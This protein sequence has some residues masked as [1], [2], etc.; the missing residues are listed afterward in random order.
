MN[1]R[2]Y[3]NLLISTLSF[4]KYSWPLMLIVPGFLITWSCFSGNKAIRKSHPKPQEIPAC[5]IMEADADFCYTQADY[6]CALVLYNKLI[7]MYPDSARYYYKRG[8]VYQK[9]KDS[10][11]CIDD[12]FQAIV[13]SDSLEYEYFYYRG[14]EYFKNNNLNLAKKD[15]TQSITLNDNCGNCYNYLGL[16]QGQ[17]YEGEQAVHS[18][19]K[20]IV[21]N[22][23]KLEYRLNLT[24]EFIRQN[25]YDSSLAVLNKTIEMDS[26]QYL[27]YFYRAIVNYEKENEYSGDNDLLH[28]LKLHEKTIDL[29]L[30]QVKQYT[31][32][33]GLVIADRMLRMISEVYPERTDI[34]AERAQVNLYQKN[35]DISL[36]L[37]SR[38]LELNP[39]NQEW[40]LQ[41]AKLSLQQQHFSE[42][43]SDY[44]KLIQNHPD[45]AKFYI[46]R[47]YANY[48]TG[49]LS[50]AR[51]DWDRAL[52]LGDP[53]AQEYI[54]T[55][56]PK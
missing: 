4:M 34:Y 8:N 22:D 38:A 50:Q 39:E 1:V 43:I 2:F 7:A 20:A 17:L 26:T 18:F 21:A 6:D 53:K 3:V 15:F 32:T 45:N 23:N 54:D 51:V 12:L 41:K 33:N 47:G 30:D 10:K 56:I 55:Y 16:I 36:E 48:K 37:Y 13:L 11:K 25:E 28:A 14:V 44:T 9:K 42:A 29:C 40:L 49:Q 31:L 46:K 52:E 35:Y 19:R 5:E 27:L 24:I